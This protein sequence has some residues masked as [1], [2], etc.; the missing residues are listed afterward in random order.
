MTFQQVMMGILEDKARVKGGRSRESRVLGQ[1]KAG[2][3]PR[4][5]KAIEERVAA[6]YK[7]ETGLE[8]GADW[9]SIKDWIVKN[10]PVILQAII[11]IL[12]IF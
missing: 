2:R 11:A 7:S 10:L 8:V 3:F 1:L 9:S 5:W 6:R 12:S 4:L